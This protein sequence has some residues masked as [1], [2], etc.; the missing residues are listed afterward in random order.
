VGVEVIGRRLTAGAPAPAA[1][2]RLGGVQLGLALR[3]LLLEILAALRQ[4][5]VA[6]LRRQ[7][8][9]TCDLCLRRLPMRVEVSLT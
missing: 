2:V 5:R 3:Q 7:V 8:R 4:P 9:R 6:V 1:A